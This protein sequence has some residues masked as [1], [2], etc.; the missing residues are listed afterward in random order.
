MPVVEVIPLG[1]GKSVDIGCRGGGAAG[2]RYQDIFKVLIELAA[3]AVIVIGT[4]PVAG[5][6][7]EGMPACPVGALPPAQG[8]LPADLLAIGNP[9]LKAPVILTGV[10]LI[11]IAAVLLG[12]CTGLHPDTGAVLPSFFFIGRPDLVSASRPIPAVGC[13]LMFHVDVLPLF[14]FFDDVTVS[15]GKIDTNNVRMSFF[16]K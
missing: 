16:M 15:N 14:D 3:A 8:F 12:Y 1:N 5:P 6:P 9:F 7:G 10:A 4:D 13:C 11:K 2:G